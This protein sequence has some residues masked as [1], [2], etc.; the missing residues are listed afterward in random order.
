MD[1]GNN[2]L[3]GARD[4]VLLR[5]CYVVGSEG[6]DHGR[7]ATAE[8]SRFLSVHQDALNIKVEAIYSSV[9]EW[10]WKGR[11]REFLVWAK[12]SPEEVGKVRG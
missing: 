5:L 7:V 3:R 10:T 1:V 6:I 4:V 12:G 2:T 11:S 9:T 8:I